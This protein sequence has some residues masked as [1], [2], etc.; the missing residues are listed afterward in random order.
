ML[1]RS[2]TC[3][4][5]LLRVNSKGHFNTPFGKYRNPKI[6]D[7]ENLRRCAIALQQAQ[8]CR[9]SFDDAFEG[10]YQG[11]FVYLDP[12]YIPVSDTANFTSYSQNGFSLEDHE[13]L[14][15]A[16]RYLDQ[17]GVKW[18][19]TNSDTPITKELYEGFRQEVIDSPR[20][21]NRESSRDV[22]I[23]NY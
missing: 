6:V 11:D 1:F 14:A 13:C 10:I 7:P 2:R 4:N 22:I 20:S 21:I 8:I 19:L 12:P 17:I 23:R 15:R 16:C 3:Y 18:M 9:C 5:G